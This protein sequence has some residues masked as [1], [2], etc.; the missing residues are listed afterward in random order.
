[1]L[2]GGAGTAPIDITEWTILARDD[3][4]DVCTIQVPSG[5]DSVVLNKRFF[6]VADWPPV[7][8]EIGSEMLIMGYPAAHRVGSELVINARILPIC[9]FVTNVGP[10]RFTVADESH[11]REILINPD[12]LEFP[13]HLGGMSGAPVFRLFMES[14]PAFLGIF[15]E[16]SDGIRGAYF[17]THAYFLQSNGELDIARIPPH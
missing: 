1:M 2:L 7:E 14:E 4:L 13:A 9:D 3:S 12:K 17:C 10:R 15:T 16:G 5:F 8:A 11:Q 6:H